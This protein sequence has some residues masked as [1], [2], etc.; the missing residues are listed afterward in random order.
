MAKRFSKR[1][2]KLSLIYF[3][4]FLM[5]FALIDYY[6]WMEFSFWWVV[7]LS[8][9]AGLVMGYIHIVKRWHDKVDEIADEL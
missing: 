7:G 8:L 1:Y 6:A 5:I 2:W 3:V 4:I 9:V